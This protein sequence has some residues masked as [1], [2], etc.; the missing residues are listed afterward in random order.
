MF[1]S[2]EFSTSLFLSISGIVSLSSSILDNLILLDSESLLISASSAT[3][4]LKLFSFPL[5]YWATNTEVKSLP[6]KIKQYINDGG[7]LLIDCK[8]NQ[9]QIII[10]KCLER[11]ETLLESNFPGNLEILDQSH[12]IAKSFYLLKNFPGRRNEQVF[13]LKSNSF[14]FDNASSVV[15]GNND[16]TGAWA[17]NNKDEFLFPILDNNPNQRN[18]SFRFGLNLLIYSLTGNYK[19]DQVHIPEILKRMD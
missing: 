17:K 14:K 19:T 10:D 15:F 16:W 7:L 9:D 18:M 3:C 2:S 13:F 11:F 12:A 5:I 8:L 1:I 6:K 4:D